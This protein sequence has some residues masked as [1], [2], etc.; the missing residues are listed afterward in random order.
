MNIRI[1]RVFQVTG[2]II[3][4]LKVKYSLRIRSVSCTELKMAKLDSVCCR[5]KP[6]MQGCIAISGMLLPISPMF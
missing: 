5:L 4:L 6:K 2:N 3:A 1:L